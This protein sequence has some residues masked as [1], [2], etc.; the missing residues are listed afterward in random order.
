LILI[1]VISVFLSAAANDIQK[2]FLDVKAILAGWESSYA[3]IRTMRLSY[4]QRVLDYQPPANNPNERSP[5]KYEYVERV[6]DNGPCYHMRYS[7]VADGFNRPEKLI[8]HAFDGKVTQTYFGNERHGSIIAGLQGTYAENC[9]HL[10]RYMLLSRIPRPNL[11][12]EYPDGVP[13]LALTLRSGIKGEACSV[14]VRPN[15]ESIAGELCHIIDFKSFSIVGKDKIEIKKVYWLAHDKGMC[16][17]KY[18]SYRDKKLI[19]DTEVEKIAVTKMDGM[20]I[21]YPEKTKKNVFSEKFGTT[22]YELTITEFVPNIDVNESTFK[23]DFPPGTDVFDRIS[24]LSYVIAGTGPNGEVSTVRSFDTTSKEPEASKANI[25]ENDV[26][27]LTSKEIKKESETSEEINEQVQSPPTESV[28]INNG[29][30]FL[31]IKTYSIIGVV[32]LTS[33]GLL[34]WFKSYAKT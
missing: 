34:F 26:P 33:I 30:G 11:K 1:T 10:K 24:G 21:W 3:G 20:S 12:D 7:K 22:R 14:S 31:N 32:I 6:E 28:T 17:M 9:N 13:E 18:Q 27:K 2:S 19:S 8:E 15:L 23:I 25:Q 29:N 4:C 16:L 5:V